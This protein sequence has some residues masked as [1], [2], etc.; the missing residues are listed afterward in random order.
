[1]NSGVSGI[2]RSLDGRSAD[3]D[4]ATDQQWRFVQ[5]PAGHLK[6]FN[7]A[8]GNTVDDRLWKTV[9]VN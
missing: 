8:G 1:M 3:P 4:N 5:Q 6:I 2:A 9:R 7:V